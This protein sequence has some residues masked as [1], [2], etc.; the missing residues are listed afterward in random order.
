[1]VILGIDPGVERMGYGIIEYSGGTHNPLSHG[2]ISTSRKLEHGE[3]LAELH[4]ALKELITKHK[5]DLV[6]VEKLFFSKNIKTAMRVGEARGVVIL[7]AAEQGIP[8]VELTP[9]EV[10]VSVAG[11]GKADKRQVQKMITTLLN[12]KETPKPDDVSDALAIAFTGA[13]YKKIKL[14]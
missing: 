2:L 9:N 5:P 4:T 1:M 12:L 6:A 10:K 11:Y 14:S 7:S 3:R 8:I 13:F